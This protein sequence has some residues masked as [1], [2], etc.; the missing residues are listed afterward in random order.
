MNSHE[1]VWFFVYLCIHISTLSQVS[2][3]S[4]SAPSSVFRESLPYTTKNLPQGI[5]SHLSPSAL[6]GRF[7]ADFPTKAISLA[8]VFQSGFRPGWDRGKVLTKTCKQSTTLVFFSSFYNLCVLFLNVSSTASR[9]TVRLLR[10]QGDRFAEKRKKVGNGREVKESGRKS[11]KMTWFR[12]C[13]MVLKI[14]NRSQSA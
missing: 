1:A 11:K 6:L 13:G 4:I 8:M 3:L 12:D 7:G 2:V 10:E 5:D 14:T 9:K